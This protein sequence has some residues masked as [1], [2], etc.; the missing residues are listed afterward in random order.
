MFDRDTAQ[1]CH[2]LACAWARPRDFAVAAAVVVGLALGTFV[3]AASAHARRGCAH[4]HT[5]I[6]AA[7]R[8]QLQN[9]VVC[10]INRERIERGLPPL[11][12]SQ[13]L[14]RAA[15]GW[16]NVMVHHQTF[17]HGAD[18]AARISAVGFNWSG[19]GEN[20][21]TGYHTPAS[22]VRSWMA[23]T[24]HCQNILSPNFADVG[25]GVSDRPIAGASSGAG[26][27]TQDFGLLMN[28]RA[29]SSNWGPAG[30]CPYRN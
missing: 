7:S 3:P 9:A 22:V 1:L 20:I 21:A 11:D 30:G 23:S 5:T 10:V 2:S 15:Q 18:F 27:W 13:R 24:G 28:R 4:A 16:T 29:P 26:T 6:A 8:H 17:S 19:V 25:S 14:N 12:T